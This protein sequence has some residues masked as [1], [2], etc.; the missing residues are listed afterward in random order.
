[1]ENQA[2][3]LIEVLMS[4]NV[5]VYTSKD[6]DAFCEKA[7]IMKALVMPYNM[8]WNGIVERKS[9]SIIETIKYDP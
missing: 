8:Q 1:M 3:K 5:G 2:S 9:Q 4:G 6:L 7:R